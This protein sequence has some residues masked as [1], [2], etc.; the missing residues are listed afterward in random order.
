MKKADSWQIELEK[1][2]VKQHKNKTTLRKPCEII[3]EYIEI[4]GSIKSGKP[5]DK[6]CAELIHYYKFYEYD[7]IHNEKFTELVKIFVEKFTETYKN[8]DNY[9]N[10]NYSYELGQKE[11]VY[12]SIKPPT[13]EQE[14]ELFMN[15][16]DHGKYLIGQCILSPLHVALE[17]IYITSKEPMKK[18][19]KTVRTEESPYDLF[20]VG[21][22]KSIFAYS[23]YQSFQNPL[24][25]HSFVVDDIAILIQDIGLSELKQICAKVGHPLNPKIEKENFCFR[26]LEPY[27]AFYTKLIEILLRFGLYNFVTVDKEDLLKIASHELSSVWKKDLDHAAEK[28]YSWCKQIL[29]GKTESGIVE[30]LENIKCHLSEEWEVGIII[31]STKFKTAEINT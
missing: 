18:T 12:K 1:T 23:E 21:V 26:I 14:K 4:T 19:I 6:L 27:K 24:T 9:H 25:T 5:L 3:I 11:A 13:N 22:L 8:L 16:K 29:L 15:K 2:M 30:F 31:K 17:E 7:V 20:P 28:F 10:F